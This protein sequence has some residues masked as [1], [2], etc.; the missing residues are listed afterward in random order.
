MKAPI[1][2]SKRLHG[3]EFEVDGEYYEITTN[4]G[5]DNILWITLKN[6][7]VS[8]APNSIGLLFNWKREQYDIVPICRLSGKTDYPRSK[9]DLG[10][11][12][13]KFKTFDSFIGCTKGLIREYKELFY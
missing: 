8:W 12:P 2:F 10:F 3:Y 11:S 9:Q 13:H 5:L 1:N 4:T 6:R 7:S